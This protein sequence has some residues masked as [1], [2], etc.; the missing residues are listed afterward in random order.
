MVG[1]RRQGEEGFSLIMGIIVVFLTILLFLLSYRLVAMTEGAVR[2]G[3]IRCDVQM[4]SRIAFEFIKRDIMPAGNRIPANL[5]PAVM[6]EE[7]DVGDNT[8]PDG[9]K[10]IT[11]PG[12][13]TDD[14]YTILALDYDSGDT[15]DKPEFFQFDF[16]YDS[17]DGFHEGDLLIISDVTGYIVGTLAGDAVDDTV[18]DPR[19]RGA[20]DIDV[21]RVIL[22][23]GVPSDISD[24]GVFPASHPVLPPPDPRTFFFD[25]EV[26]KVLIIRYYV[27]EETCELM[28]SENGKDAFPVASNVKN[29]QVFYDLNTASFVNDV[30]DPR[31]IRAVNIIL[32][33]ESGKPDRLDTGNLFRQDYKMKVQ[34]RNRLRS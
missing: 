10:I 9:L 16:P 24:M 2:M 31:N 27:N 19:D 7:G 34:V 4:N 20:T 32:T 33:M 1:K 15:D 5:V 11:N 6:P 30:A 18:P 13:N 12:D 14:T 28:R 29:M 25:A 23:V 3:K 26:S 17:G 8:V 22:G 21:R